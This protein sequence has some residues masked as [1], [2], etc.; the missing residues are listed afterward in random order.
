MDAVVTRGLTR[1]FG[2]FTA[3]QAVEGVRMVR[4]TRFRRLGL[5]AS[6]ALG[7]GVLTFSDLEIPR[8]DND[9]NFAERGT[10]T[11]EMEGGR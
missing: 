1:R 10:L 9:P 8:L 5:P 4:A 11:L 2:R 7:T 3:V 6:S